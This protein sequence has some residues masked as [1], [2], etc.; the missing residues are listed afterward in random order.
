MTSGVRLRPSV[1]A[2]RQRLV[3][4]REKLR[5]RHAAGSP[6]I[7]ISNALTDLVDAIVLE[8]FESALDDL[9]HTE[10]G[11][12]RSSLALVAHGGYGRRDLAPYSDVDLM[13]LHAPHVG[14]LVVPLAE[15][16]LRDV[17][18]VGLVPGHS[19]RTPALACRLAIQDATI[20]T[21]LIESR[22]L[23][24]SQELYERFAVKLKNT[25]RRRSRR[26][27][28]AFEKSRRDERAQ[29]G[30]TV[31]LL[32]PNIKRSRGGLRDLH[33]LRWV[34]FARYGTADPDGLQLQGELSPGD[35]RALQRGSEFLLRLRHEMHFHAEKACDSLDRAEQV[36]VA[37]VFGFRGALA[38]LPVEQFM[39]EYFRH[40]TAINDIATH[41]VAGA[42]PGRR[43][44]RWIAPLVSHQ[45]EGDFR[46]GPAQIAATRRGQ[47]KFAGNL[48]E[49]L[50]LVDLANLY[51]KKI[52]QP[53]FDAIREASRDL[54]DLLDDEAIRH[55]LSLMA[56]PAR[57][58]EMLR[59]LHRVHV[60]ERVIPS[61][62]H[63]RCLLQFNE[64]HKFTVDEHCLRAVELATGFQYDSGPLGRVYR[65]L[66]QKR[67]LHLALLIHDLGKGYAEDHS[68]LG[69]K[70]AAETAARLR[71]PPQETELLKFLVHKHLMMS[72]LAFRRDTSEDQL[73]V[74]FAVEVGSP[75]ALQMLYLLTAADLAA[76]GPGVMNNWKSEVLTDL[77]R[78]TMRHLAGEGTA[79]A[80]DD[81]AEAS[82]NQIRGRLR[83]VESLAWYDS[84]I[85]SLPHDYLESTPPAQVVA[86]LRELHSLPS[87]EVIARG[88]YLVDRRTVEY[89]V[90]TH[91]DITPGV[92]HKLTG[93]LTSQGLEIL[94]AQI[95]TLADGLVLD[96]FVV[97]DPDFSEEPP[98]SRIEAV[99]QA[100]GRALRDRDAQPPA[101]R[102]TWGAR[103]HLSVAAMPTRIRTDN[104]TSERYTII[105][106]FAADRT[107]LLYRIT[108][109]L[110]ELGLSVSLAKIATYLDQ[111]V[112]VFYVT[113]MQGRKV[114]DEGR[115]EAIRS[116]LLEEIEAVERQEA[117]RVG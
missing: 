47:A 96:R 104:S 43:I 7:Q 26:M 81:R 40:T 16:M 55:F 30:E 54:P 105:D 95:N 15:R 48:A 57:L 102:R 93:A 85:A 116:R 79:L 117:Q 103:P 14:R 86:E 17:C 20:C 27:L 13:L 45:V 114:E 42:Q 59:A 12:L 2:A 69:L 78:R 38:L 83:N 72:H 29:Y 94:A 111:V 51:N 11:G 97:H 99:C 87:G 62:A 56:Q 90:G 60:L 46:V 31:Y 23:A 18:D 5:Q 73:V 41:F 58:G 106:V 75:D 10:T 39:Q 70:I 37:E 66:K 77:Y 8:L 101:F 88:R 35:H 84:V 24:G 89:T 3:E 28:A 36:R 74:R 50:R 9:G 100:L 4:G 61:F 67:A 53:T 80:S 52:A 82:R 6:G 92:F 63:A 65:K 109:T 113:D 98:P 34:G 32:E 108:R 107:G 33:W 115:I 76:V 112:D 1:I 110:F 71:L 22:F 49:I 64:Y 19:V 44:A 25:I 91:E 68:E 21:S